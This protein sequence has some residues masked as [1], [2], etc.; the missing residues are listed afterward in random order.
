LDTFARAATS[1]TEVASNPFS[2]NSCR[3]IRMSCSR[4]C[5]EDIRTR[6]FFGG[7][8][9]FGGGATLVEGVGAGSLDSL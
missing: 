8:T 3:P 2:A 4:R 1:S 6:L 9:A 7:G 5:A